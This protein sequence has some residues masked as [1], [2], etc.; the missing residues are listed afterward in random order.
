MVDGQAHYCGVVAREMVQHALAH[1][2]ANAP[3]QTC[4]QA[5]LYAATP[6]TPL[7]DIAWQMRVRH[8]RYVPIL[9]G[10]P[11]LQKVVGIMTRADLLRTVHDDILAAARLRARGQASP[12]MLLL[13]RRPLQGL[14][15]ARLPRPCYALL[16]RL[17][18]CADAHGVS[19]YVVGDWVRD[20]LLSL[21][22]GNV[23][24][25][26]QVA[27]PR[28]RKSSNLWSMAPLAPFH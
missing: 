1:G 26:M 10:V 11:P 9:T 6:E 13:V 8:Q 12:D 17:G 16:E 18:R 21:R 15:R 4:L 25:V 20:L 22:P 24:V 27:C 2:L 5:A 19:A 14:L 7:R 23:D 3:V 28:S